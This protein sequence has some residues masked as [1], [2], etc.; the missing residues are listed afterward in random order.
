MSRQVKVFSYRK[1]GIGKNYFLY[2]FLKYIENFAI[3]MFK[4]KILKRIYYN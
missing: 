4:R 3:Q 2:S 1:S